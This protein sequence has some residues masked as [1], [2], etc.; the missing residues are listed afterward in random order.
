MIDHI[1]IDRIDGDGEPSL[2]AGYVDIVFR[3]SNGEIVAGVYLF[4]DG[5]IHAHS[6]HDGKI[7]ARVTLEAGETSAESF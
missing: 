7:T 3:D 1:L 2:T 5:K 4:P 6:I